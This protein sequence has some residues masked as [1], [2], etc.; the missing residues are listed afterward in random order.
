MAV[1]IIISMNKRHLHHVWRFLRKINPLYFLL[2]AIIF[3]TIA[4]FALR[5]NNQ[6][7]V[8][9]RAAVY[10]ADEKNGDVKAAIQALRTYIYAHMNTSL[11][12][13]ANAVH[14]P[15]Q[16]KYTYLGLQE[17]AQDKL[18]ETNAVLYIT[19]KDY[20]EGLN[21][22]DFS[23]RNRVPCVEEYVL[24]HGATLEKIPEGLYK[25]DF[26]SA[27]WSPDLAGWSLIIAGLALPLFVLSAAYHWWAKKYL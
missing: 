26:T 19:A 12:T 4:V 6:E 5:H 18:R 17:K 21:S 13:G 1:A 7:M 16:L 10:T 24:S 11:T 27:K 2:I 15:I 3:G 23:G 22:K 8:R 20:C 25:F 14:P 9:L